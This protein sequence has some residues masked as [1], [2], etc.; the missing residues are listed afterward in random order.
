[1]RARA[2]TGRA[3]PPRRPAPSRVPA[4]LGERERLGGLEPGGGRE[5][6]RLLV[7][8]EGGVE[9][10][11]LAGQA[12]AVE[13]HLRDEAAGAQLARGGEGAVERLARRRRP[14]EPLAEEAQP[15]QRA[16]QV[17][18]VVGG[19]SRVAQRGLP[20]GE[21]LLVAGEGGLEVAPRLLQP[22]QLLQGARAV[23]PV[24]GLRGDDPAQLGVGGGR[25]AERS[26]HDGQVRP[27]RGR[28]SRRRTRGRRG[29]RG[30]GRAPAPARPG[31]PRR[32]PSGGAPTRRC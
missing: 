22:A 24:P 3:P 4:E 21:R 12:P 10:A 13:Q 7:A 18:A 23:H 6:E 29:R 25:V 27:D 14:P 26:R 16:H 2:R 30:R 5:R 28:G 1:M 15:A 32:L 19:R 9:V 31:P 20:G 11:A 8:G 17:R